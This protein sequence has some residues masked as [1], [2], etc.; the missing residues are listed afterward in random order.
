MNERMMEP[1]EAVLYRSHRLTTTANTYTVEIFEP[2]TG[3]T[4][5]SDPLTAHLFGLVDAS[6]TST[7]PC[8]DGQPIH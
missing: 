6:V 3:C 4:K 5:D 7:P 1:S 2:Q 8:Q